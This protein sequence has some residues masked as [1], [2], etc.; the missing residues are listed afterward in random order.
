MYFL[1]FFILFSLLSFSSLSFL[2]SLF[3]LSTF[4]FCSLSVLFRI[5]VISILKSASSK[6]QA[7]GVE[8]VHTVGNVESC[9]SQF[10]KPLPTLPEFNLENICKFSGP[11]NYSRLK[12]LR[13]D[14]NNLTHADLP[15]DSSNCLRQASDIIF[16]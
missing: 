1:F 14:G 11:L 8:C 13:L 5:V 6:C 7:I 16:D 3:S 15:H 2:Y 9:M 12:H 4:S 10:T